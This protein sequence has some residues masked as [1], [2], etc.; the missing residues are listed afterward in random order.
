MDNNYN[1]F[2][3]MKWRGD[4]SIK[5]FP[6]NEVD[7]LILSELSY[8][9]FEGVVPEVGSEEVITIEEANRRYEKKNLRMLYYAE[10][11]RMFEAMATCPRY[12]DMT[13][14][15]YTSTLDYE[16][17]EQFAA[18]HINLTPYQTFV[19]FRGTDSSIVG[20]REDFNMSY[21]MPVPAQQS[22]VDYV[23]QT[24]KGM[25]RKY[26]IGGHSKGGNLAIYSGVFCEPR[27]QK[28]LIQIFSF[29]GPGFN[30]KMIN[31]PAYKMVQDKILAFVPEESVVGLLMEHEEDYIVVQS[32]GVSLLQHEGFTWRISRDNFELA[33]E[34]NPSSK[35]MSVALKNWLQKVSPEERKSLVDTFFSLFEKADI[36]DFAELLDMDAK[37]T[38][39]LI[40]AVATVPKQ[41]RELAGKLIKL[42]IEENGQ[43]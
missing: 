6:L 43:I 14:C 36:H 26:Y 11:E 24:V 38:A 37:T 35:N 29:D 2:A 32:E 10:K 30:R 33:D 7:A 40:K 5:E 23:N 27:I 19:A 42:F 18:L 34:L 41:E 4:L 1:L 13:L 15:N 20:W 39:S 28:K 3:Y 16:E 21:M 8:I 25:F 9:R 31:D 12:K 22:A 17:Q